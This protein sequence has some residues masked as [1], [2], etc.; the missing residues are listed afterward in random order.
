MSVTTP[1]PE[2]ALNQHKPTYSGFP[3]PAGLRR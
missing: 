3:E 1:K 2:E